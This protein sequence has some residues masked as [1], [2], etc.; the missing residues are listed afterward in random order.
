MSSC[1]PPWPPPYN[2]CTVEKL[3]L[4]E[5]HCLWN[6]VALKCMPQNIFAVYKIYINWYISIPME[7]ITGYITHTYLSENTA[8]SLFPVWYV[9]H[10]PR[11]KQWRTQT[12]FKALYSR[13][14][15]KWLLI[16]IHFTSSLYTHNS[17]CS[18]RSSDP[19]CMSLIVN[20]PDVA[21]HHPCPTPNLLYIGSIL[22]IHYRWCPDIFLT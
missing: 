4:L 2:F 16:L 11:F 13:H 1:H 12:L 17:W 7:T 8:S 10:F 22:S 5:N 19:G 9:P 3:S 14:A 20:L 15:K 18:Y 6:C 21:L